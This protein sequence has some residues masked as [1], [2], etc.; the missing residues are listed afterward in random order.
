MQNKST[1]PTS[2]LARNHDVVWAAEKETVQSN[3]CKYTKY[4]KHSPRA[5]VIVI[6]VLVLGV[7]QMSLHFQNSFCRNFSRIRSKENNAVETVI[8]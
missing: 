8:R 3:F 5:V 4:C 2:L 7:T 1:H 6:A